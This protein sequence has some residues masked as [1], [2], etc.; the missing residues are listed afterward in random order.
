MISESGSG[1]KI[2]YLGLN[3]LKSLSLLN[4][5]FLFI[6][7]LKGLLVGLTLGKPINHIS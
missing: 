1:L 3:S 4:F 6:S 5:F 7:T 2:V